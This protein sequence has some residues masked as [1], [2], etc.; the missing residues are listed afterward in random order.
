MPTKAKKKKTKPKKFTAKTKKPTKKITKK[1]TAKKKVAKSVQEKIAL[2]K[3]RFVRLETLEPKRRRQSGLL[4]GDLQGLST[5][6]SAD[7]ESV[8][9]LLEEGN[10]LEAEAVA[11]VEAADIDNREVH[12]KEVPEDDVPGEYEDKD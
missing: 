12:T 10:T 4:A 8:A 9:E 1:K 5:D 11:G 2:R 3:P 7:S 6:E